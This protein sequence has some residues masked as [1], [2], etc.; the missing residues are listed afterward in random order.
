[1]CG[2]VEEFSPEGKLGHRA[3]PWR[4]QPASLSK[5]LS[6]AWLILLWQK[7]QSLALFQEIGFPQI[8]SH[9]I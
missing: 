2:G 7:K 6:K 1:V 9:F 5:E 3:G 4:C 8:I